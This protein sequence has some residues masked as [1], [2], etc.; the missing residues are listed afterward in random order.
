MA[1]YIHT[2]D[3]QGL[4]QRL[5][6]SICNREI[7]TWDVDKDGDYTIDRDQWRFKAW[8]RPTEKQ[9]QLIFGIVQSRKYVMTNELYGVYHGR[10]VA[11]ILAN[12]SDLIS[13]VHVT[14]NPQRDV[15]IIDYGLTR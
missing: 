13:E 5:T 3:S 7:I 9:G 12:F 8:F 6:A 14:P 11:T 2:N 10:L 4:H 1:I 15:D